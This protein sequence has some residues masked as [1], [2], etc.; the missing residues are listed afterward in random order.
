MPR[1]RVPSCAM[2]VVLTAWVGC[3][4]AVADPAGSPLS[5]ARCA[6]AQPPRAFDS[7][8]VD[9]ALLAP[10]PAMADALG[11]LVP[12]GVFDGCD[13]VV[14][15]AHPAGAGGGKS[16]PTG[17]TFVARS[18]DAATW[19]RGKIDI[20]DSVFPDI[21]HG[22]GKWVAV[23]RAGL[24]AS[25]VIAVADQPDTDA[26][27][28]VFR[29]DDFGFDRVAFGAGTF[30][31]T[32]RFKLAVSR[33]G[34]Q[35]AWATLPPA[36]TPV[37]LFDVAYGNGRFVVAGVGGA[38]SSADGSTWERMTCRDPSA[39]DGVTDGSMTNLPLESRIGL[40]DI[41]FVGGKFYGFGA[42]G[43]LESSD[44]R[45]FERVSVTFPAAA[46]G[47]T[48]VSIA[49]DPEMAWVDSG[50]MA[51]LKQV[52]SSDDDGKTWTRRILTTIDSADCTV[53]VC[54][55]MPGAIL[56]TRSR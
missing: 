23:G 1:M 29:A 8:R 32:S 17:P 39:C 30:V 45:T 53:D 6:W 16:I 10:Q 14:S 41:H 4:D 3:A 47:G 44:G 46:I 15:L 24:G 18:T 20:E 34:V 27:R 43:A 55:V 7:A 22:N 25:G 2:F 26:W 54:A 31:A 12:D 40:Q 48:L 36:T 5:A 13:S 21:A 11:R 37:Q 50:D 33:D 52:F 28:P 42:S 38:F 9:W 51:S 19:T 49:L 35:W 56:V